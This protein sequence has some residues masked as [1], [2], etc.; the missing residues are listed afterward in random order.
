MGDQLN[1]DT[2]DAEQIDPDALARQ[3]CFTKELRRD[4]YPAVDP[5]NPEINAKGKKVLITGGSHGVGKV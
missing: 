2:V 4:I 3:W 1:I 5:K